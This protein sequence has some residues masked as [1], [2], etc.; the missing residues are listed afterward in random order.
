MS[1]CQANVFGAEKEKFLNEDRQG[2]GLREKGGF[3]TSVI[4]GWRGCVEVTIQIVS[5][6]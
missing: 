6:I 2:R 1:V 3:E 4:S 5:V